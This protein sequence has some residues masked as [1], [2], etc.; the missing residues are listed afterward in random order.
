[1]GSVAGMAQAVVLIL[2]AVAAA[3]WWHRM[4]KRQKPQ[5]SLASKKGSRSNYHCVEV[6]SGNAACDSVKRLGTIRFLSEEAPGLPLPGCNV[7]TCK[8]IYVHYDNRRQEYRRN[9]CGQWASVP[10]AITGERRSRIERRKSPENAYRPSMA[11]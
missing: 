8:C 6:R 5:V 11:S 3:F 7:Q 1:M 9:P 4:T 2:I 10:P